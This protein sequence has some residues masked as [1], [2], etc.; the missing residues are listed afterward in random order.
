MNVSL[1]WLKDYLHIDLD[2]VKVGEV[3]TDIGLE[4]EG[5]E[6]VE[7]IPGG[8]KGVV[9]GHVVECG[10]H[11]NADK[12]SLT[13]VDVG[14]EEL[15][16]IV[17][18]A[19]N[20][21]AGQKVLVATIGTT[22]HPTEGD[23]FKIKKGKIR[24]EVSE[25]MI[26]AEDEIGTGTSHDGILVLPE[27]TAIGMPA[28]DYF[29][30]ETDIVYEIGLTPNRSDGTNHIGVAKDLAAALKINYDHKGEVDLPKVDD[31]AIDSKDTPVEVVV[32][33]TEACPRYSGV[34][35]KGVTI[36]ES[37]DWLKKRLNAIGVR[38][39]SNMVDIT[40]FVLHELGQP[41]HAFDL[42]KITDQ[43]IIVKTL[44]AGSKFLSLDE[45]ER[46]LSAEDL[47]I[48]D[49]ASNGM[50]I[51]GVFGGLNSGV[52]DN[53]TDI[54]LESAHFDAKYIRRSSMRHNLRTEAAKV[55]EKGSDPNVT[56]YALKRAAL[57]MKELGGGQI[58]SEIVDIYPNPIEKKSVEVSYRN[59]RRL[60][61]VEIPQADIKTILAA[62]EMDILKED[63]KS[64]TVA[65][66]TNK[67]DVLREADVIEEILRIYGFNKVP[68]QDQITSTIAISPKPNP[69]EV[70]NMI[71]DL[72]ASNGFN[73]MMAVSL[74]ESKYYKEIFQSIK[75]E[76]LVYI[77]NTS[78]IHLDV[79]RPTMLFSGLEAILHNQNRQQSNLRLFE[80][81]RSYLKTEEENVFNE[82]NHL[83]LYMTGTRHPESWL[84]SDKEEV[85]FYALKAQVL[86]VLNRLGVS[87]YQEKSTDEETFSFGIQYHRGPQALV[88]FGKVK[89]SISKA[90]NIKAAVFFAEF[91][92]DAIMKAIR[93]H[94]VTF[95]E[96]S[97]FPSSRRDL[98]LVVDNSVK[99]VDIVAIAKKT[100]KKLIKDIN[101]FDVYIN[102][103]QLGKDKKSYAV[104]YI[105]EDPSKTL[106]DKDVDKVM[107][108]LI[109]TYESKLGATIRR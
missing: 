69:S 40:N 79:M 7:S 77:N 93:K 30:L 61:G 66:P 11:P 88:R 68:M 106:K 95:T 12:L 35:I 4:V 65:V 102:E 94:Q 84:K 60:I 51:G 76:Q 55:F 108:Q 2:A 17:C 15:L 70:R 5:M 24:G 43:K 42:S 101:L 46:S 99:F 64:F 54:F 59:V 72:L 31:F 27:D 25:G 85:D 6:E 109:Q 67:A 90:M 1:N 58:A 73:E 47:M 97:K 48:C 74:S 45:V 80:Y 38:P 16:Q 100:G 91:N 89:T 44:P 75:E 18:G 57:L 83:C 13:K 9:V 86:Q 28:A 49:G 29:Q 107:N 105:F 10:K 78:N 41:L 33:N 19:P 39:I 104:S 87:G 62:L 50:C 81:G 34:V 26:C 53:T 103:Q 3:L 14:A 21:A 96:I 8:L 92:W 71:G 56:L 63:E 23:P 98:A 36:K 32:E 82:T 22:L 20:V 52:T 37:P